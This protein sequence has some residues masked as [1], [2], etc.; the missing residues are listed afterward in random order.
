MAI[1]LGALLGS[2]GFAVMFSA[3]FLIRNEW[4]F[5]NRMRILDESD[6][7]HGRHVPY[8]YLPSYDEMMRRFWIWNADRFLDGRG[9]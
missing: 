3:C 2:C 4:V 7:V 5:R 6:W 1:F 9:K 8:C